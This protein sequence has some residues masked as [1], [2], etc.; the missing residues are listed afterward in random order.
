MSRRGVSL[1]EINMNYPMILVDTCA[2]I[3]YLMGGKSVNA[4][5]D[6]AHFFKKHIDGGKGVYVTSSVFTEYSNTYFL[7]PRK[8][9]LNTIESNSR[10]L[11]LD[12]NE[13]IQYSL[14]HREYSG[15]K[16]EFYIGNVDYDFLVS[17]VVVSEARKKPVA[18]ISNDMGILRAWKFFLVEKS[19]SPI[20]LKFLIRIGNE[21]FKGAK[22]PKRYKFNS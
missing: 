19:L 22:P 4:I 3:G 20:E 1:E 17:G 6:S 7:S 16:E 2:L 15:I 14:L 13:E 21:T 9:L 18:L 11:Q 10:I 12:D 5:V 8:R